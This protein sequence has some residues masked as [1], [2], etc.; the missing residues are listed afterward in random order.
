ME[1]VQ[2]LPPGAVFALIVLLLTPVQELPSSSPLLHVERIMLQVR[3]ERDATSDCLSRLRDIAAGIDELRGV[4]SAA[5]A[6][7][8]PDPVAFAVEATQQ[9]IKTRWKEFEERLKVIATVRA[10]RPNP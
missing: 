10:S 8:G 4:F 6:E 9:E 2:H 7:K 5:K 1:V 3:T